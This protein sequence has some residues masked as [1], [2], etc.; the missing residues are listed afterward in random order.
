MP[1]TDLC[2]CEFCKEFANPT[3]RPNRVLW[4]GG[5]FNLLPSIGS[6]TPGYL[7]LMPKFHIR[8]F[9]DLNPADLQSALSIAE[10]ARQVI[11]G[12]FGPTILAEHGPGRPGETSAACCD[13]AHWHLIPCDP[14]KVSQEYERAAGVPAALTTIREL[15]KW[16]GQ[17]YVFLSPL[18]HVYWTWP[19]SDHFSSQFVRRICAKIMGLADY[20]DWAIF[21]FTENMIVTRSELGPQL[22]LGVAP[23][24]IISHSHDFELAV[25]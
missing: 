12:R 23:T 19:Y 13:H 7:L 20:Y 1:T 22:K 11:S 25:R 15:S 6:L 18:R 5:N 21:P 10:A 24:P 3:Q 17:P 14:H 2:A 4:E 16:G 8:S 9:A